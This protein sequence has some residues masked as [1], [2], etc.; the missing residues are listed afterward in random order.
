MHARET[1]SLNRS[2]TANKHAASKAPTSDTQAETTEEET[3]NHY[4]TVRTRCPA[5]VLTLTHGRLHTQQALI[6]AF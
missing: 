3:N 2:G 4:E 6:T 5:S 1:G